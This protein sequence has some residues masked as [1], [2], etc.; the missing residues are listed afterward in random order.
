MTEES[1]L[2]VAEETSILMTDDGDLLVTQEEN[3]TIFGIGIQGLAGLSG[4]EAAAPDF[5]LQ[6]EIGKL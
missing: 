6:Y 2:A 1:K 4:L 5:A 3:T